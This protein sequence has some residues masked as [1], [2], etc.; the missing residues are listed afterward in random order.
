MCVESK[1]TFLRHTDEH[2]FST[3]AQNVILF[4]KVVRQL[5]RGFIEPREYRGKKIQAPAPRPHIDFCP[6][7]YG[8]GYLHH[9]AW[10]S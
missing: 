2:Y 3:G 7:P 8:V 4:G 1:Y 9:C 5:G 10:G 6:G